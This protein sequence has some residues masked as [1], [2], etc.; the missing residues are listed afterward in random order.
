MYNNFHISSRLSFVDNDKPT[1][2]SVKSF[3]PIRRSERRRYVVIF[4]FQD[5]IYVLY[6][7]IRENETFSFVGKRKTKRAISFRNSKKWITTIV[8]Y[9]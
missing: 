1:N 8:C 2:G 7:K 6:K 9:P 4:W 5:F 3:M